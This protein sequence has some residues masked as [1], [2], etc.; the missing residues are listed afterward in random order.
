MW[1]QLPTQNP[2]PG[3]FEGEVRVLSM[4]LEVMF[5]GTAV[6]REVV[7]RKARAVAVYFI[8]KVTVLLQVVMIELSC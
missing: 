3:K 7:P 2:Q 8:L 5:T 1:H 6:T 4:V